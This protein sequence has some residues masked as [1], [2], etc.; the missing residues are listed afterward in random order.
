RRLAASGL[1][2]GLSACGGLAL[3]GLLALALLGLLRLAAGLLLSLP[4]GLLLGLAARLL[5]G[6][7]AR[8]LLLGAELRVALAHHVGDGVDDDLARADRVVVAGDREG[9]RGRVDVRVD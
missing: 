2:G 8:G 9:D 4:P 3:L 7:L 1:R 6:L 5:L